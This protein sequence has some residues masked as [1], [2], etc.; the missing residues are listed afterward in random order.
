MKLYI[1]WETCVVSAKNAGE[2]AESTFDNCQITI[3]PYNDSSVSICIAEESDYRSLFIGAGRVTY[4]SPSV[5][6][7]EGSVNVSGILV[8]VKFTANLN[9][10]K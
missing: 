10:I 4:L 3:S 2:F 5:L 8:P 1:K 7:G 9:N 6:K